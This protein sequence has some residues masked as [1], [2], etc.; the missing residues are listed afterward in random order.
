MTTPTD[1][2]EAEREY[3]DRLNEAERAHAAGKPFSDERCSAL[4][5]QMAA[6]MSLLPAPP[7]R[8]LD[9]G[10]GTGWTSFMLARRGYE[11]VGQDISAGGLALARA[12][13]PEWGSPPV[14][15][16]ESDFDSLGYEDEFDGILFFAS[17]HHTTDLK[18][19][20]A[21]AH[22]AL[23]AGGVLVAAEPGRGHAARSVEVHDQFG[24][25][26]I[27]LPPTLMREV[28]RAVGFRRCD[29]YPHADQ[30]DSV[31]YDGRARNPRLERLFR[32]RPARYAALLYNLFWYKRHNGLVVL[33]K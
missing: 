8:I 16:V 11:V 4:L 21:S 22:R 25:T 10:C 2:K 9:C 14:T 27:D 5:M 7:A 30:M 1:P 24:V 17:L 6:C 3:Y 26:D 32:F 33:T 15:F 23:R 13:A 31:L 29:V 20:L 28:G 19:T 12:V 18:R